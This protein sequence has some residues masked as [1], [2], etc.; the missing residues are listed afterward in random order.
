VVAQFSWSIFGFG[1]VGLK[2]PGALAFPIVIAL[3]AAFGAWHARTAA[4]E[5]K[6]R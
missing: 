6:L 1:I 4:A 5:G 2:G 3:L